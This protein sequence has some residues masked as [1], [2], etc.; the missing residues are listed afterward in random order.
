MRIIL[1]DLENIAIIEQ[2]IYVV[3]NS[4]I[5]MMA[6]TVDVSLKN[7]STSKHQ[8]LVNVKVLIINKDYARVINSF[9]IIGNQIAISVLQE[10]R[11]TK[12][13][14]L[15]CCYEVHVINV[16]NEHMEVLYRQADIIKILINVQTLDQNVGERAQQDRLYVLHGVG[17]LVEEV[18]SLDQAAV[19]IEISICVNDVNVNLVDDRGN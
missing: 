9:I 19:E 1:Q 18:I 14:L 8:V 4:C 6:I 13:L 2:I 12:Y 3:F 7:F 10:E 16:D 15:V 11:T 5:F 17:N